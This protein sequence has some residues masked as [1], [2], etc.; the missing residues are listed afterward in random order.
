MYQRP[1]LLILSLYRVGSNPY[2][3][4]SVWVRFLPSHLIHP[5]A[6]T[7]HE[8]AS[9]QIRLE[10]MPRAAQMFQF[11]SP[12][13]CFTSL[14][15]LP[16]PTNHQPPHTNLTYSFQFQLYV[17]MIT[18]LLVFPINFLVVQLFRNSPPRSKRKSRVE[19]ALRSQE[20]SLDRENEETGTS[21]RC[22]QEASK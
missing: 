21:G 7:T 9:N 15:R 5:I 10:Q 8:M 11:L 17:G 1:I 16:T 13:I 22:T 18:N 14:G 20:R 4:K 6:I 12:W 19:E 3:S 2:F